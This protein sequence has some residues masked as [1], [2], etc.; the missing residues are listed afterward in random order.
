[1]EELGDDF[2]KAERELT[3]V[4]DSLNESMRKI[5]RDSCYPESRRT[6]LDDELD[7]GTG[8]KPK[9]VKTT[10]YLKIESLNAVNA[11]MRRTTKIQI[12]L[13]LQ[14]H[15]TLEIGNICLSVQRNTLQHV[16][17]ME[18]LTLTTAKV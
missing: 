3:K 2:T 4:Q 12:G 1:M 5:A 14:V 18:G 8:A 10:T 15:P 16:V 17:L 9:T 7:E 11:L 6:T 13:P